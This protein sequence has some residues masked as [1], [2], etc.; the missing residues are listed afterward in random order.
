MQARL[1]LE[2]PSATPPEQVAEAAAERLHA[3]GATAFTQL[4]LAAIVATTV[5][6]ISA[7]VFTYTL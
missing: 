4:E 7:F 1:L 6:G 3:H 5:A 2:L